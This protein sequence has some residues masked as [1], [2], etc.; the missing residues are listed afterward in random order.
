MPAW[1]GDV[2]A[3]LFGVTVTNREGPRLA[4]DGFAT[5]DSGP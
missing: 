1:P 2:R 3:D 5:D 4:V